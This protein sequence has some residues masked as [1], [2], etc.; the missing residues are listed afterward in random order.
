MHDFH[1]PVIIVNFKTYLE[2]TGK[3][4]IEL[5]KKAEKV[6][7][8]TSIYVGVAPQLADLSAVAQAVEIPVFAQ[9]IDPIKPGGYTGHVLAE[10]VKEA[11]AIGTLINHSERRLKLSDIDEIVKLTREKGL[12]SVVCANN[13][14]TSVAVSS[15]NPDLVAIEPPEL[16]GTGI[17][18]SKA[19]PEIV[20]GTVQLVREVNKKITILCGAGISHGEDVSAAL[21][22][23]TQGVLVASGIVKA[24]DPYAII[25]EF[26]EAMKR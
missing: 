19:Q 23:G 25:L 10:A 22:L 26:A 8:E 9:H 16:I 3:R 5:A 14:S 24:K 18:V 12:M 4:A 13:P 7:R 6:H 15:L 21:K 11:G 1:P 2:S 17:P 20:S